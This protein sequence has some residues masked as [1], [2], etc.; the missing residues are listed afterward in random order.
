MGENG[1]KSEPLTV[2][3]LYQPSV[4]EESVPDEEGDPVEEGEGS[5]GDGVEVEPE[6]E[7]VAIPEQI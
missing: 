3:V 6:V 4:V 5:E 7:A 1:E 2:K